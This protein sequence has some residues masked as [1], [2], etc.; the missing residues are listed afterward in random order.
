MSAVAEL[1]KQ[2]CTWS[3]QTLSIEMISSLE[4][5]LE[6]VDGSFLH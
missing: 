4:V 2:L 5:M 1:A 6:Y 3:W